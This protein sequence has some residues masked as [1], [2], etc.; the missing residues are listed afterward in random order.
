[1]K[2]NTSVVKRPENPVEATSRLRTVVPAVDIYENN[3]EILLIADMPGISKENVEVHIDNGRL[4][5]SGSREIKM[6]GAATWEEFGDVRFY[7][8]FSV[9]QSIDI[10]KVNAALR[11]G[12]LK[13]HLPKSE[14]AKPKQIEI[15]VG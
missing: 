4:S 14:K 3:D 10:A 9:P 1:M 6:E 7:R 8:A 12:V 5:L 15:K 13:L 2:E 11:D